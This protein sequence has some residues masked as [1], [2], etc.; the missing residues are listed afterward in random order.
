MGNDPDSDAKISR[1]DIRRLVTDKK[2]ATDV[3]T[4][5]DTV[6]IGG[7]VTRT[8]TTIVTADVLSKTTA[9][10]MIPRSFM[11]KNGLRLSCLFIG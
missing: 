7:G 11:N 3:T 6:D 5:T 2:V 9:T 10:G 8:T 4:D 1:K